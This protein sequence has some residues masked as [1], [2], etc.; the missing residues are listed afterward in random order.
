MGLRVTSPQTKGFFA[1]GCGGKEVSLPVEKFLSSRKIMV[2]EPRLL[3]MS[4][5]SAWF[6]RTLSCKRPHHRSPAKWG[7]WLSPF[8]EGESE[9]QQGTRTCPGF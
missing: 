3:S 2:N 5:P 9:A 4:R 7:L 8:T 1:W 6:A